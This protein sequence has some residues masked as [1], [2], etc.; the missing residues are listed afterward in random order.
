MTVEYVKAD[1]EVLD[2]LDRYENGR[3]LL[4]DA[5]DWDWPITIKPEFEG[6]MLPAEYG[7]K[8]MPNSWLGVVEHVGHIFSKRELGQDTYPN[9][10]EIIDSKQMIEAYVSHGMP[11]IYDHW[12]FGKNS[13]QFEQAYKQGTMGLAYEVVPNTNPVRSYCMTQNTPMMQQLVIFHAAF[14]HNHFFKNNYLFKQFTRAD[15]IVGDLIRLRDL[16]RRCEEREG[17]DKVE[18][19]LDFCHT[20]QDYGVN[21]YTEPS[22]RTPK[23]EQER[24]L[25]LEE[26]RVRNYDHM[27]ESTMPGK[28][29]A[30]NANAQP[31]FKRDE[32]ILRFVAANAPKLQEWEREI[33]REISNIA[34][35]FYPQPLLK[36]MN[37]GCA[38]YTHYKIMTRLNE[39]KTGALNADGQPET[40]LNDGRFQ[41]FLHSHTNV[42]MQ[43]EFDKP[44]YNG[45]NPYALGFAICQD[46]ERMCLHP[47]EEDRQWFPDIAG[48][49]DYMGVLRESW[50]HFQ[51]SSYI[52]QYMSPEVMRKFRLFS[53]AD[54]SSQPTMKVEAIH[55]EAGYRKVRRDLAAQY[56]PTL[57]HPPIE[58]SGYDYLRTRTLMLEHTI[59]NQ[60]PLN[61]K[62]TLEVLKHLHRVWGYPV[63]LQS[64]NEQ[65]QMVKLLTCPPGTP[66]P[67]P[68]PA[69]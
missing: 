51:D 17:V 8:E 45:I 14:G 53:V 56:E 48:N 39:I 31:A 20:L 58:V 69:P 38:T 40:L 47:T 60:K 52:Q 5:E 65:G 61:E 44:Y 28:R 63:L 67:I 21:R 66:V 62:D 35:Y 24:R 34:Q 36:V 4:N 11:L 16:V 18:K 7:V 12:S 6:Q 27:M 43:P 49:P 9:I 2:F 29:A 25:R 30:F 64:K 33:I 32:N 55:N 37:E 3:N 23:E 54:D 10:I 26:D 46:L 59:V 50:A 68:A 57:L 15:E 1:Q 19:L 42:V 22:Q 13:M 41:E